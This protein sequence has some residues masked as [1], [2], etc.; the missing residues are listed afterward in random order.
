MKLVFTFT[1]SESASDG[2]VTFISHCAFFLSFTAVV[3]HENHFD[4][5][6]A[7]LPR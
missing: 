5:N 4:V 2:S 1:L 7:H 6:I 3:L